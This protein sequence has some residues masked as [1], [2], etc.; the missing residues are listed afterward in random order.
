MIVMRDIVSGTP[1]FRQCTIDSSTVRPTSAIL[2]IFS[3]H[4]FRNFARFLIFLRM[5]ECSASTNR[6]SGK[7]YYKYNDMK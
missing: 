1:Y 4:G 2:H 6:E 5:F 7:G 3:A